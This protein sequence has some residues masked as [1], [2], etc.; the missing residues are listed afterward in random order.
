MITEN[1]IEELSEYFEE[2][3]FKV[4]QS[5]SN[6]FIVSE[7]SKAVIDWLKECNV[8]KETTPFSKFTNQNGIGEF[9]M[10]L[11]HHQDDKFLDF[12]S[13]GLLNNLYQWCVGVIKHNP[14]GDSA[15]ELFYFALIDFD[16]LTDITKNA[17]NS[18]VSSCIKDTT[19]LDMLMDE[20]YGTIQN[21]LLEGSEK[22]LKECEKIR[23]LGGTDLIPQLF[24]LNKPDEVYSR[25]WFSDIEYNNY[26]ELQQNLHSISKIMHQIFW[27]NDTELVN[28]YIQYHFFN[29]V[30][31]GVVNRFQF[32]G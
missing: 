6:G 12:A 32:N 15:S 26:K 9:L 2:H 1:F 30:N 11:R 10:H 25:T 24:S 29:F 28:R 13:D 19:Y 20:L 8:K 17:V 23:V 4:L 16:R 21:G 22:L 14:S 31:D 7:E 5:S 3:P 27:F 18:L